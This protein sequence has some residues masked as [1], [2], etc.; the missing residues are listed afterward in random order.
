MVDI[1]KKPEQY[2]EA[3]ASGEIRL[4]PETIKLIREGRVEKGDPLQIATLAGINGTKFTPWVIPLCHPIPVESTE[5][6]IHIKD[7][8]IVVT[9]K[10]IANSKTGVEMEALTA[11]SIA[12][13]N[14]WD[15][16]KKYEKDEEGQYP[17]TMIS[18]IKVLRKVKGD[19]GSLRRA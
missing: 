18:S 2:R 8:S 1:S 4:K 5:V 6:D 7:E 17:T 16:V 15:V 11:T 14:I 19:V 12:L 9:T 13:L 10:V 3:V